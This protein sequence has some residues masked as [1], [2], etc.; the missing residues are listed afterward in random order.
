[1]RYKYFLSGLLITGI[2]FSSTAQKVKRKGTEPIQVN[3][4]ARAAAYSIDQLSG[5]WQ[6]IKRI[7]AGS[8]APVDFS[9][10][11]LLHIEN[12]KAELK[13]A[14][15]MRM[16]MRGE[17]AIEAP[18]SLVVAG[19]VYTI[20]SSDSST[21]IIDD[22]EFTRSFQKKDQFYYETLGKIKIEQDTISHPVTID[23]SNLKG[24]WLVYS[25][26]AQPGATNEQTPIIR[27]LEIVS[28]SDEGI[29]YG[30][31]VFYISNVTK[32]VKCQLVTKDGIIKIVT[33]KDT[34]N[35]FAYKADGKEFIFGETGKL[36]YYSK[37]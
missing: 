7:P 25:R 34:W 28:V 17:A 21:L 2:S 20:R 1:M 23:I 14:T 9:D 32:T 33:D 4:K 35:L 18:H 30:E 3:A 36:V 27:S 37:H 16:T 19:D 24:K 5:R 15:S 13:D 10:S 31:L 29:A 8:K 6:E 22:G 12:G 11:L 26:K